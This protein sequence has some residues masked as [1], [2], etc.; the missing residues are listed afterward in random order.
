MGDLTLPTGSNRNKI[1]HIAQH[2]NSMISGAITLPFVIKD[3]SGVMQVP[4]QILISQDVEEIAIADGSISGAKTISLAKLSNLYP[5]TQPYT[6]DP[7]LNLFVDADVYVT[8]NPADAMGSNLYWSSD[9]F[10]PLR[11]L[12]RLNYGD[13]GA[14]LKLSGFSN[15]E[16]KLIGDPNNLRPMLSEES[17]IQPNGGSFSISSVKGVL[18]LYG[19]VM[20]SSLPVDFSVQM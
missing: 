19:E 10:G 16:M 5:T 15:F 1:E 3:S 18:M 11:A 20:A 4:E 13:G 7:I 14:R 9:M 17:K 6:D 8:G 2:V 12:P